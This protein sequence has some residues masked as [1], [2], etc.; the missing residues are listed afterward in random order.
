MADI[1]IA[2]AEIRLM[3]HI[4]DKA[5]VK[6]GDLVDIAARE[7]GWNR[8]TTYTILMRLIK[9][10]AV[11]REEPNFVCRPL[12]TRDDVTAQETNSLIDR[13]YNGSRKLF[14]TSYLKQE[15]LSVEEI[16]VIY[17]IIKDKE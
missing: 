12:I 7:F 3:N 1:K 9:K 8:N 17:R 6:A 15:K 13:M 14:L 16:E 11:A 2:D 10:G 4:W 5:P